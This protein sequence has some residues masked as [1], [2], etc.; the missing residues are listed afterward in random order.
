MS[1][2]FSKELREEI[3][4]FLKLRHDFIMRKFAFCTGLLGLGSLSLTAE[5]NKVF[6]LTN[7]LYLVP[8]VAV[9]FDFQIAAEDHRIKRAGM[10]LRQR[11]SGASPEERAY[12]KFVKAHRNNLA[13]F[14]YSIVT[15]I[16]L[17]GSAFILWQTNPP[18]LIF[19][20]WFVGTAIVEIF[21]STY[22]SKVRT[23]IETEDQKSPAPPNR[24]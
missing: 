10:F 4:L 20:L 7:L 2:N 23:Y 13:P 18:I 1:D 8:L 14:A 17:I 21:L 15:F 16:M 5:A 12:E 6:I 22:V 19:V 9:A 11:G 3:H 24:N